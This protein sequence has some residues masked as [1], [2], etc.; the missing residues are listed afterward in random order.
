MADNE[1]TLGLFQRERETKNT[2]LFSRTNEG[3]RRESQYVP[4]AVFGDA[5]PEEVEVLIRW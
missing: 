1:Q 2:I 5:R 3:G 4:K